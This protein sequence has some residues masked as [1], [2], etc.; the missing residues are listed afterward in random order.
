MNLIST[1]QYKGWFASMGQN[2]IVIQNVLTGILPTI[3]VF[4]IFFATYHAVKGVHMRTAADGPE[5]RKEANR[6]IAASVIGALIL[7]LI[8]SLLLGLMLT[9]G[10]TTQTT[11]QTADSGSNALMALNHFVNFDKGILS[12]NILS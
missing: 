6:K 7:I 8:P 10:K 12:Y 4:I 9:I 3:I 1:T 2:G 5:Q 11:T